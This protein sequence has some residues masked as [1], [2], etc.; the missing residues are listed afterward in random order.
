MTYAGNYKR[1]PH[2]HWYTTKERCEG[3]NK[4]YYRNG[5]TFVAFVDE[6]EEKLLYQWRLTF[7]GIGD[8]EYI[9]GVKV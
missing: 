2:Y 7:V 4:L 8:V 5:V 3:Y 1:T 9:E 6:P